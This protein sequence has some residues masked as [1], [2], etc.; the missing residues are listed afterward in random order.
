MRSGSRSVGAS[1]TLRLLVSTPDRELALMTGGP[2]AR[3]RR[4]TFVRLKYQNGSR[5]HEL[6]SRKLPGDKRSA[7]AAMRP[8][9]K[10]VNGST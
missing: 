10:L 9:S 5:A 6:D 8:G 2:F 4:A 3:E 1:A 7:R